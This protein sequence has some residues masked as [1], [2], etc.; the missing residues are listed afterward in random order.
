MIETP[1]EKYMLKGR[2]V[3]VKRD[4]LI[5][6]GGR[7][8]RWAKIEGIRQILKDESIISRDKPLTHLSVYG[9]WTGWVLSDLCR[10]YGIPFVSAY[11]DSKSFPQSLKDKVVENGGELLPLKPNMMAVLNGILKKKALEN[12]WQML[13][14]AF[15]HSVYVSYMQERMR[16]VLKDHDFDHLVISSGSGVTM[17]GMIK[18]F[19]QVTDI[20]SM[21]ANERQVH[22]VYMSSEKSVKKILCSNDVLGIENVNLHQSPYAFNDIMKDYTVPFDCNEFWDKKCWYWLE[23]NIE[24]LKGRILFWNLGGS[25]LKSLEQ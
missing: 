25:F 3:S 7:F 11:S 19:L 10:E 17:S 18:E 9:S 22:S 14:Y 15:N 23:Q 2:E 1:I 16:V 8:P 20:M 6:D 13:P 24:D 4:D 12:D 5:G 21:F